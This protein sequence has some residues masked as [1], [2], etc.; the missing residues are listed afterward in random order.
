MKHERFIRK[1]FMFVFLTFTTLYGQKAEIKKI[2]SLILEDKLFKADSLLKN[3][4]ALSKSK[5]DYE[6]LSYLV[7]WQGKIEMSGDTDKSFPKATTLAQFIVSNTS[8][9]YPLYQANI[10][11]SRLSNEKGNLSGAIRLAE[12][13]NEFALQ[14]KNEEALVNCYYYLGEYNLRSGNINNFFEKIRRGHQIL[15]DNPEK[16]FKIAARVLNYMGAINYFSSQ[17]DSA[18]YYY[19]SALDKVEAMEN[20]MEN[21]LYFPAAIKANMVLLK[22]SQNEYEEALRL[23]EECI[24]LNKKF[25]NTSKKH[26]LR[27]RSQRNLSLAY[28]NLASLYEQIGDYEKAHH[29]AQLAFEHAKKTF[30]PSLLEYFSAMTLLAEVKTLQ[31]NYNDALKV[32]EE[33][34]KSL[35]SMDGNI[36]LLKANYHTI[37]AGIRYGKKNFKEAR[38]AYELGNQFHQEA[39]NEVYSSDRLFAIMNLAMC[40]A[41]L[42]EE[43]KAQTLLDQTIEYQS[44]QSDSG[45]LLDALLISKARASEIL[46]DFEIVF[47]ATNEFISKN[48]AENQN[49]AMYAQEAEAITLKSKAKFHLNSEKNIAFL[50]SLNKDL[51]EAIGI[52]ENR[53]G[54]INSNENINSLIE[55]NR[56]VFDFAKKINLALYEKTLDKKHLRKVLELH[57]SSIYNRIRARLNVKEDISFSQLPEEVSKRERAIQK[58]IESSEHDVNEFLNA[59]QAWNKFL[60]SIKIRYPNYYQMRYASLLQSLNDLQEKIPPNTTLIRYF[61]IEN[62]LHVYTNNGRVEQLVP[63]ENPSVNEIALFENFE[64]NLVKIAEA[65]KK[66]YDALWKPIENSVDTKNVIIYP[67]AELFNL[68]FELLTPHLIASFEDLATKSLLAKYNISYNYSLLLLKRFNKTLDFDEDFVAFAPEF[69]QKMKEN[70]QI[71]ILDSLFLD[72]AYLTLLPQPFSS[73]LVEKFS[74]RFNGKT[75]LNENASKQL[76]TQ[77]AKEHKIIHIGTHAESNNVSPEL[78]RLVFAKNV[79]DAANIND[80]YLYTYEIYNQNL[81]TN[82]AILTACETGKPTYQPGEGMIS[83]AHAFNYAGS[84]SILTS[85]WQIDEQSSTAIL[86]FFYEYLADGLPK[87]EALRQAKLEYLQSAE[88]RTL[89]PQYWAGLILMGDTAPIEFSSTSFDDWFPWVLLVLIVPTVVLLLLFIKKQ[90]LSNNESP[91][92]N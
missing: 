39:Q 19:Q 88:G 32:M 41:Q 26:P 12:K 33:A 58:K 90:E 68:S 22:Q 31:R 80:N 57:E 75:F 71:A 20:N 6:Q 9:P 21:R 11:L 23:A 29:I 3:Q 25:L 38:D 51:G 36:P 7:Y 35:N 45:R 8:E 73:G 24:L 65:S 62:R 54:Y 44:K 78:S 1:I 48:S 30:E 77:Y 28:R 16:E 63:L 15:F 60:D 85:L 52:L 87:D 5:K 55:E 53:K 72:R 59:S 92:S 70:Y 46:G 61:K 56:E 13:A 81:A 76:F 69:D 17:P 18:Y 50:N 64:I 89:H 43:N 82:L 79:S 67:D 66:L 34:K 27:F 14:T 37:L 47:E 40:Y 42:G 49:R 86:S 2:E 4:L 91:C 84:E 74:K 10:D 83:L